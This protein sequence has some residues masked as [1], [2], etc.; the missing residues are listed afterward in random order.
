[1]AGDGF[2]RPR[3]RPYPGRNGKRL[4]FHDDPGKHLA[5][6]VEGGDGVENAL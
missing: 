4:L 2:D 3:P 1:M 6:I 5:V